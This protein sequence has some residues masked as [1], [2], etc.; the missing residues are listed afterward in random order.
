V[1]IFV[2]HG[3]KS[4]ERADTGDCVRL[5][6][7]VGFDRY[8]FARI[9]AICAGVAAFTVA[10]K[11]PRRPPPSMNTYRRLLTCRFGG[12]ARYCGYGNVPP[13]IH[14]PVTSP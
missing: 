14:G 4:R 11:L 3:C 7:R 6:T 8:G 10:R 13:Q 5:K 12:Y 2:R 1:A 9:A